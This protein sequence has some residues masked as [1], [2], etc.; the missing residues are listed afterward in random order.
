MGKFQEIFG[1]GSLRSQEELAIQIPQSL[2]QEKERLVPGRC[3]T[4][5]TRLLLLLL[6]LLL[7]WYGE[8][9][10]RYM[11]S[12]WLTL[13]PLPS[14]SHIQASSPSLSASLR[15]PSMMSSTRTGGA[16]QTKKRKG[17]VRV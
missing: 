7:L 1:C 17:G 10:V 5:C 3:G 2:A 9:V 11:T 6:L 8:R 14:S 4:D 13:G 12:F 15:R 16:E